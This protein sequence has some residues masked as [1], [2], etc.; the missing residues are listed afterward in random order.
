MSQRAL[1]Y[2]VPSEMSKI[3]HCKTHRVKERKGQVSSATYSDTDVL[4]DGRHSPTMGSS[5]PPGVASPNHIL[6]N[7]NHILSKL[8]R[9]D[10]RLLEPHLEAVA[11]NDG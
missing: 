5:M 4:R 3:A 7:P 11:P 2:S 9:A 6:S 8:S 1:S 10:F